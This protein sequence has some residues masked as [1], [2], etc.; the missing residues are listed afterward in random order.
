M[1]EPLASY[2]FLPWLRRGVG[3]DIS[4][5][6]G[7]GTAEPRH[8][9]P[10]AVRFNSDD[11]KT[12]TLKLDLFGPG[13]V[14]SF[15]ARAV[16]RT[17]PRAGVMDA[18]PNFF[19]AIEFDQADLPWRY[20]PAR[21]TAGDR[22][23]PWITLIV[24]ADEE[25]ESLTPSQGQLFGRVTV[26]DASVLPKHSQLWA[27]A[28]V[29]VTGETTVSEAKAAEL[30]AS[31]GHRVVAR[32]LAPRRMKPRVSYTAFVVPSFQRGVAAGMGLDPDTTL[33]G[34]APAWTDTTSGALSLPI[35]YQWRFGTGP[36][37]DF[38]SLA[39]LIKKFATPPT[40]GVRDM[41]VSAPSPG[42]PPAHT[43]PLG[44]QGM[45]RGLTTPS[46]SWTGPTRNTWIT[47]LAELLNRPADRLS[48]PGAPR[49]VTPPLYGQWHAATDRS[50]ADTPNPRPIWFQDANVD[51]RYRVAAALGTQVVQTSQEAL[52]AS[53]WE[54][55]ER[56]RQLNEELR[57]AQLARE[58]A[59]QVAKR[60]VM[61]ASDEAVLALTAPLHA[62][63]MASP[64]TIRAELADSP[65]PRGVF[66]GAFRRITRPLGPLAR[67]QSRD[68]ASTRPG[69]L[70][71]LNEGLSAA[72]AP[73][74]PDKMATPTTSGMG[75]VPPGTTQ[76]TV[77]QRRRWY[78]LLRIISI[79]LGVLALVFLLFGIWAVSVVLAILAAIAFGLSR[80]VARATETLANRLAFR[81]G[82]LTGKAVR[83]TPP[84]VGFVPVEG[85][86]AGTPTPAGVAATPEVIAALQESLA[87]V[88]DRI[89]PPKTPGRVLHRVDIKVLRDKLE[90]ALDPR[91]TVT[92]AFDGRY[93]LKDVQWEPDDPI[94]PIM[95]AP[96]FPQPM[97][98]EL[99]KISVDWLLP[100]YSQIPANV[101]TLLESNGNMID[102]YMVGLNHEM[103]RELLWREY[104]T[105]QRGSYF[106]Q[107]WDVSGFV[108][109]PGQTV[110]PETLKDITPLHTWSK[111]SVLGKHSPRP[112][113]PV[114]DYLVL[115]VRGDLL[116]RYPNTT[117]YAARAR[118]TEGSL[119]EIHDPEPDATAA[120]IAAIQEW[121]MFS[122]VLEPDGT[123]F[124]FRLTAAE[125]KGSTDPSGDPGWYFVL[126]E[127]SSEPRF[128]LDEAD[129][130][131]LGLA[132]A[133]ANWNDLSWGSLVSGQ[134]SLDTITC[135]DLDAQ[136]PDTARVTDPVTKRWHADQGTGEKGSRS[137]DIAYVTLQRPMRVGIHGADMIP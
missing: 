75:L 64:R 87:R 43:A 3:A 105:D 137:S 47:W 4:R 21:A 110:D 132:V 36:A 111:G 136:L 129:P 74:T 128:G 9:L 134:A 93:T 70:Q 86:V 126:Q 63:V 54:Q 26:K 115:L 8:A 83:A 48:T 79:V 13:E 116:R 65:I 69:L 84:A 78:R 62:R 66:D 41:D 127:H 56:I 71:R 46:T 31:D 95:A 125:A 122:G 109:E 121:P 106:R 90:K 72:P 59:A 52:M 39:R 107:F 73:P 82:V 1:M 30:L 2:S 98:A 60:H 27:W 131:A 35:Y 102:A 118:W 81:D 40:V 55:V 91:R 32:M 38:E 58:L 96:E 17:W 14:R 114:G 97:Y 57:Q 20:T 25:I 7:G 49:T 19:P 61:V 85:S 120:E 94:E 103:A 10:I 28:H 37:G 76:L 80:T 113:M 42:A 77:A 135:I 18:E 101:A 133:G 100:G 24:L 119:R 22:L 112:P 50:T 11:A 92:A 67:R 104:P 88:I 29:Q 6:D 44:M 33:D 5:V 108:P 89:A 12:G 124:G 16:I 53:A 123:F 99:K 15:D 23:T 51:P 45:L 117:V 130:A 68:P 34:L